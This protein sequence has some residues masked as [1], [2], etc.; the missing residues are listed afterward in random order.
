MTI[1]KRNTYTYILL[2]YSSVRFKVYT[3]FNRLTDRANT[4]LPRSKRRIC[5]FPPPTPPPPNRLI[6]IIVVVAVVVIIIGRKEK[7]FRIYLLR[8]RMVVVVVVVVV[9]LHDAYGTRDIRARGRRPLFAGRQAEITETGQRAFAFVF[10]RLPRGSTHPDAV[11]LLCRPRPVRVQYCDRRRF[12]SVF[13]PE[14]GFA[15]LTAVVRNR[16]NDLPP[17]SNTGGTGERS[18]ESKKRNGARVVTRS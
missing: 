1:V 2:R 17:S 12:S 3:V 9:F 16:T 10:S 5:F 4:R 14:K 8:Y 11:K 18:L 13:S 7:P 15:V 6:I